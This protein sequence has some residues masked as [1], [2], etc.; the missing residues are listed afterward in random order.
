MSTIKADNFTWKSGESSGQAQYTVTA[1]KVILGT[2]KSWLNYNSSS[3]SINKSFNISSVTSNSTGDKTVTLLNAMIDSY[4]SVYG[5][6]IGD[7]Q[8]SYACFICAANQQAL[9]SNTLR[10]RVNNYSGS[11]YDATT[12]NICLTR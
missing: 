6:N 5:S 9:T 2:A 4:F 12:V 1:D 11:L 7:T 8:A 3:L 10:H